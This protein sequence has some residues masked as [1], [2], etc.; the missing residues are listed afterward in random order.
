MLSVRVALVSSVALA[1]QVEVL[2][3]KSAQLEW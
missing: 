1:W 2:Q 3:Q